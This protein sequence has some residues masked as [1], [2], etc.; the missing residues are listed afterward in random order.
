MT[1]WA[2]SLRQHAVERLGVDGAA[3]AIA[4]T[5]LERIGQEWQHIEAGRL[6]ARPRSFEQSGVE[7]Q[8]ERGHQ[9]AVQ[10]LQDRRVGV[11]TAR[12]HVLRGHALT[13]VGGF[14]HTAHKRSLCELRRYHSRR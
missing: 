12:V 10:H 6:R 1:A 13:T 7:L 4:G 9:M 8:P 14:G 11:A 5:L 2:G 3:E